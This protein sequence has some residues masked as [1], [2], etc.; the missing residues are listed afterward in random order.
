[1]FEL[2]SSKHM[3]YIINIL[4]DREA[5]VWVATNDIL[6]LALES[7]TIEVLIARVK[8]AAPELISLNK[9]KESIQNPTSLCFNIQM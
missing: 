1:M 4:W 6:G 3:E 5:N 7:S 9:D 8:V 2:V